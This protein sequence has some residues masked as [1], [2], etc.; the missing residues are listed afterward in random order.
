MT[1]HKKSKTVINVGVD[2]G[3]QFLDVCIHEKSLH[4]QVEN[5][6]QGIKQLYK[7][8]SALS[9]GTPGHGGNGPI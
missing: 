4:W 7:A 9:G 6:S 3:K 2:V 8:I 1:N 5:N